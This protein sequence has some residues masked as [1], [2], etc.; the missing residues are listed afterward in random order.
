MVLESR[1]SR[2][3]AGTDLSTCHGAMLRNLQ[4][5]G[6]AV[7]DGPRLSSVAAAHRWIQFFAA[8][9]KVLAQVACARTDWERQTGVLEHVIGTRGSARMGE[10][11]G[12]SSIRS[13]KVRASRLIQS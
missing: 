9:A 12:R 1:R 7:E 2:P 13:S 8:S 11:R 6:M 5:E 10:S 3:N 4:T